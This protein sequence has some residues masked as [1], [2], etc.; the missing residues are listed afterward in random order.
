MERVSD[1]TVPSLERPGRA[2]L[3][4]ARAAPPG[5][6]SHDALAARVAAFHAIEL[7]QPLNLVPV[8]HRFRVA[9]WNA[10]R[11]KQIEASAALIRQAQAD[12]V[13]LSEVDVGMARS[14][15]RH[16]A[17]D[18]ADALGMGFIYGVEFVELGLGDKCETRWHA[19]EANAV[20]F[21]GNAILSRFRLADP[22][23]VRL[24]EGGLWFGPGGAPDQR[25]LGGRMALAARLADTP[26]PVWIAVAHLENRSDPAIRAAQMRRLLAVLDERAPGAACVL[27]GDLNTLALP[28]GD[29]L[30]ERILDDPSATEPLFAE[31]R[32]AGFDWRRANTRHVTSRTRPDGEPK[33]PFTRI[34]WLFARGLAVADPA[35]LPA[36]DR[37]GLAISDHDL[38]GVEVGLP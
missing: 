24:D 12:V 13:L 28:R 29:A 30:P 6:A 20:G 36:L 22:V 3:D 2:L 10:E 9:A 23:L 33:P 1:A 8:P 18:L 15:N 31:M 34:D 21:H 17:A 5:A 35:T 37:E 38:I 32:G 27:G 4:E 16:A 19:G 14:R 25:R 26:L 11:L 7:H